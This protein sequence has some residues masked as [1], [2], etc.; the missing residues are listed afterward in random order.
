MKMSLIEFRFILIINNFNRKHLPPLTELL[1]SNLRRTLKLWHKSQ[2]LVLNH[3]GALKR[4]L[5]SGQVE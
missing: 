2:L 5:I 4:G 3:H 1:Q